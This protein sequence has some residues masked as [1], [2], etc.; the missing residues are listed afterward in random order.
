MREIE[1]TND[2]RLKVFI[3][4]APGLLQSPKDI[5]ES[6]IAALELQISEYYK[7]EHKAEG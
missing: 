7:L 2:L 4:G 1:V 5:A 6:I 3:N